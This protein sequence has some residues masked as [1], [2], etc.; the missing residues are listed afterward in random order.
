MPLVSL[1][2]VLKRHLSGMINTR[3]SDSLLRRMHFQARNY[4]CTIQTT[5]TNHMPHNPNNKWR[6][7]LHPLTN[8]ADYPSLI[9]YP[10]VDVTH[11]LP[12]FYLLKTY[13]KVVI[14]LYNVIH[15]LRRALGCPTTW[16]IRPKSQQLNTTTTI[17]T[18]ILIA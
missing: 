7:V 2:L 12:T 3:V 8:V 1:F 17:P 15:R 13:L 14:S 11:T 6:A 18:P 16:A 4:I 9:V 10:T 5:P